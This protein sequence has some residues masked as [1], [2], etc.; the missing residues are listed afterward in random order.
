VIKCNKPRGAKTTVHHA[1]EAHA[2]RDAL[3][4]KLSRLIVSDFGMRD[5]AEGVQLRD[6]VKSAARLRVP[7]PLE[8]FIR[9]CQSLCSSLEL[10]IPFIEN[11]F[12]ICFE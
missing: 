11:E 2:R 9:F 12:I 7:R 8:P 10:L 4:V 5:C 6:N 1:S 3:A